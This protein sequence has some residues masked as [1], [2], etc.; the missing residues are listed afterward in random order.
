MFFLIVVVTTP[1][2]QFGSVKVLTVKAQQSGVK[3]AFPRAVGG[4][5]SDED[6][7]AVVCWGKCRLCLFFTWAAYTLK[8]GALETKY[9]P[10]QTM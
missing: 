6:Q 7:P 10:E 4:R 8:G 2:K 1:A 3:G 9:H 5:Y